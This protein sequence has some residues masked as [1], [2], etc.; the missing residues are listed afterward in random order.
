VPIHATAAGLLRDDQK[1]SGESDAHSVGANHLLLG[2]QSEAHGWG[3]WG[4]PV[5]LSMSI[6]A[7]WT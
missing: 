4:V 6:F 5:S 1:L 2:T 3:Y 7:N